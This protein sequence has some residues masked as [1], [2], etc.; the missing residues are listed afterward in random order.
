MVRVFNR[1]GIDYGILGKEE[2]CD[3]DSQRLVGET[4][5]FE[6]LS[7]LIIYSKFFSSYF[8]LI[9][10]FSGLKDLNFSGSTSLT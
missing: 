6:E 2:K 7:A 1:L 10:F 8:L 3:G 9:I 4:G 5:L